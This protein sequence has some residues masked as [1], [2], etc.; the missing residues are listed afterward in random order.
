VIAR[1]TATSDPGPPNADDG[2]PHRPHAVERAIMS[3]CAV[4]PVQVT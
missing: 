3:A 4:R 1:C 2:T